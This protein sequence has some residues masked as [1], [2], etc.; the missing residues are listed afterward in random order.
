MVVILLLCAI[1]NCEVSVIITAMSNNR[2]FMFIY[3]NITILGIFNLCI[4]KLITDIFVIIY[5][6]VIFEY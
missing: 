2:N 5:V 1:V 3:A 6:I 4:S